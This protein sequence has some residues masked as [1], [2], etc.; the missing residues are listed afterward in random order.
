[1]LLCSPFKFV[2]S[3]GVFYRWLQSIFPAA[4]LLASLKFTRTTLKPLPPCVLMRQCLCSCRS[5]TLKYPSLGPK[6]W[7]NCFSCVPQHFIYLLDTVLLVCLPP[8]LHN[9]ILGSGNLPFIFV[10]SLVLSQSR[11]CNKCLINWNASNLSRGLVEKETVIHVS[12][13][14]LSDSFY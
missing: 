12:Y 6:G 5:I 13:F 7:D 9:G 2:T 11:S 4:A 1:M 3:R 14:W 10:F 8:S